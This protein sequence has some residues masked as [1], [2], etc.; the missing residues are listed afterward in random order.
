MKKYIIYVLIITNAYFIG[1]IFFGENNIFNFLKYKK[2]ISK[3]EMEKNNVMKQRYKLEQLSTLL[4]HKNK[5]NDDVL[6][7]LLRQLV[8]A[9]LPEEKIVLLKDEI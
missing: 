7:E 4:S 1:H 3:L 8:Q 2:E 5:D 9:S 6:D